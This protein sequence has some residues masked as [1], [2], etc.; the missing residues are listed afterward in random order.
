MSLLPIE[1]SAR[2]RILLPARSPAAEAEVRAHPALGNTHALWEGRTDAEGF[3]EIPK[4]AEGAFIL[5][6]HPNAGSLIR[7]WRELDAAGPG[8]VWTL[9]APAPVLKVQ[10]NSSWGEP[11]PRAEMALF[12]DDLRLT[13]VTL[14]WFAGA[15]S[16]GV[17]RAGF[18]QASSLPEAPLQLLAWMPKVMSE[19]LAG[20]YD[21]L[22]VSIPYPWQEIIEV[23]AVE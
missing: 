13:G 9:P 10:V 19:V 8:P 5:V 22:A 12:V 15:S 11:A 6:R 4:Q 2:L 21:A 16:S 1:P 7:K 3:V 14:S 23:A 20:R 17:N 18:W